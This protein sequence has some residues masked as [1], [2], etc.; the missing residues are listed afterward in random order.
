M[1]EGLLF[2]TVDDLV[3][4][5]NRP[6]RPAEAD[7]SIWWRHEWDLQCGGEVGYQC[8]GRLLHDPFTLSTERH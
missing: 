5:L 2:S 1:N 6:E 3:S 8:G 4:S 7:G